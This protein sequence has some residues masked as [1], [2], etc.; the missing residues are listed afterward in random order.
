MAQEDRKLGKYLL[1]KKL[2]EGG[3]GVVYL[4]TDL[5]LQRDVALKVLP[6]EL[7][8]DPHAV[9]RF[10]REARLAASLN[11]P[12]VV[13]I[14]DVDQQR[15]LCFLVMELVTG[16]STQDLLAQGALHWGE[17]TRIIADAC[18]GLVAAHGAGLVHRDIK[19]SN[20]LRTQSGSIKVADFGLARAQE[21]SP[22]S[23][24]LTASGALLGT[25]QYMSP[26]QCQGEVLDARSDLYSLGATYF[27]L[28]TRQ[29]PYAES[30][31]MQAMFAHCSKPVP[32]PIIYCPDLPT[33]CVQIVQRALAKKRVDR[34]ASA[35]DM[36][37]A[38]EQL[39]QS[40]SGIKA[41]P[42]RP[43]TE[44]TSA[45]VIAAL[46]ST[47]ELPQPTVVPTSWDAPSEVDS[48]THG[49]ESLTAAP[50]SS[51]W[52]G[53]WRRLNAVA[54]RTLLAVVVLLFVISVVWMTNHRDDAST[55]VG[56]GTT[57]P[58]DTKS[59]NDRRG[60]NAELSA[61]RL[62]FDRELSDIDSEARSVVFAHDGRSIF[63]AMRNG[64]VREWSLPEGVPKRRY[65]TNGSAQH[66]VVANREWLI[67]GG[68]DKQVRL[69]RLDTQTD[70]PQP[71]EVGGMKSRV[72]ALAINR[73]GTK[74]AVATESEALLFEL[75][76]KGATLIREL[77]RSNGTPA[78]CY[79]VHDLDF[80]PDGRWLAATAWSYNAMIW[81]AE[82]GELLVTKSDLPHEPMS[83]TFIGSNKLIVGSRGGPLTVWERPFET[84]AC[85]AF[86][87]ESTK[88]LRALAVTEQ[89]LLIA[90]GGWDM[91]ASIFDAS[92]EQLLSTIRHET[93]AAAL[94]V[95]ISPDQQVAVTCGGD[96]GT[97]GYVHLWKLVRSS[98]AEPKSA[99]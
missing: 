61:M 92:Q 42:F 17:A 97:R 25:P 8:S 87:G 50:N 95:A 22:A 3:M 74:L 36:L 19:P 53:A 27:A 39:L 93:P 26:E 84:Q 6:K 54:R 45:S 96:S 79:M 34:F 44:S 13:A 78:P 52:L 35:A 65:S 40:A 32:N 29:P 80:S 51:S 75:S 68:D 67:A 14:H 89:G 66:A 46:P 63:V 98:S 10:L 86:R 77:G 30:Q 73:A 71:L 43:I 4:A 76:H 18:R 24:P 23:S 1:K 9:R 90:V 12:H 56:Q 49:D 58:R 15:G 70:R 85:R 83:L 64:E 48:V 28:L 33:D 88:E 81:N 69:W 2:G 7:S 20:L 41:P 60:A 21:D 37:E 11:H 91:P 31:P 38:L 62:E 47:R 55:Y 5:R 57:S 72:M 82:T 99:R 94:N 16:G 59:T